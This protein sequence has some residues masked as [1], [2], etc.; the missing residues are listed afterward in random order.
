MRPRLRRPARLLVL[1]G[2]SLLLLFWALSPI[3]WVFISSISTRIEL[4]STPIKHWIPAHPTLDNYRAVFTS[5][6]QYRAGGSPP[7]ATLLLAG[8][9]NSLITSVGSAAIITVLSTLAAYAFARLQFRGK[10]ALFILTMLLLPL[11]IWI[12]LIRLYFII[13]NAGLLDTDLALILIFVA[14]G[15]PLYIWIMQTYIRGTPVEI[16]EAALIDG[17]SRLGALRRVIVPIVVP[18]LA[19]VFLTALLTDWNAFVVPLIFTNSESSQTLPVVLS[20]FIGQYEVEWE[21]MSAAAMVT[22][23]PPLLLALFFQRYLVRG[24][25]LGAIR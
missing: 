25:S 9:R 8:L 14:Y 6:P 18:G 7:S 5:G 11:P 24:L 19:A 16:E 13:T 22:L 23:L 2:L 20:L 10:G 4:Y 21:A 15:L 12:S 1:Y 3:F 17:C